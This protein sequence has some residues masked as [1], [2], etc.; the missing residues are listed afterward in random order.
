MKKIIF[1][2]VILLTL[3]IGVYAM[4]QHKS[5]DNN[6]QPKTYYSKPVPQG[7]KLSKATFAGGC[8]WCMEPPFEKLEGVY[9]VVS[10]YI[11][12]HDNDPTY[13]E[14]SSGVTGHAEAVEVSYD[15]GRVSYKQ[16]LDI[17]WR[18]IDPTAKD[19][20]F[21]D[22]GTQYRTGIFYHNEEQKKLAEESKS[23][24]AASGK[25]DKPIV[26]E[27][28]PAAAFFPAEDYHQD[29]YKKN[30]QHYKSYRYLSGREPFLDKVW[31]NEKEI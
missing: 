8:F 25:F 21:A 3:I 11:G 26:T 15:A 20:Q 14:V 28:V 6:E 1:W 12:G 19:R 10:G 27:I 31:K 29:Y 24:L 17:F 2:T 5:S 4:S 13:P 16:L 23:E 7:V 30:P 9:A 18:N 22:V